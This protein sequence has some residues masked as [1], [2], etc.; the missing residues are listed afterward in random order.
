MARNYYYLIAGLPDITF[1]DNKLAV[2]LTTFRQEIKNNLHQKDEKLID[3][4]YYKFDNRNLLKLLEKKEDFNNLGIF[5]IQQLEDEIKRVKEEGANSKSI[6]PLYMQL[7]ILDY[8][9]ESSRDKISNENNLSLHY[10]KEAVNLDNSFIG[11]YFQFELNIH[12]FLVASLSR[13]HNLE[14]ENEILGNNEIASQ[15]RKSNA[16]DFNLGGDFEFTNALLQLVEIND[17]KERERKID[18][19]RWNYIENEV[20]FHYFSAERLFAFLI[21]L[22]IL[23]RWTSLSKEEGKDQFAEMLENLKSGYEIPEEYVKK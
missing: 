15:I 19:L 13:K 4:F 12:N 18:L 22:D 3:Y 1:E 11:K 9:T 14:Y 8:F 21:K 6:I 5:T 23:E 7:F 20:F 16:K 17:I 2:D 10:Y